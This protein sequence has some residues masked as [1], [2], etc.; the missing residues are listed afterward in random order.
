MEKIADLELGI[1]RQ[2]PEN[3]RI[4][5]RYNDPE[6]A[7]E[8][9]LVRGE[10][11]LVQFDIKSLEAIIHDNLEYGKNLTNYLFK[12]IKIKEAFTHAWTNSQSK[13]ACLRVRLFIGPSAPELHSL[14]WETLQ[15]PSSGNTIATSEN[16]FFSRYLSSL[17]WRPVRLSPKSNLRTLAVIANPKDIESYE[18]HGQ[19]LTALDVNEEHERIKTSLGT[20]FVK[21]LASGGNATL[22]NIFTNLRDGYDI[23]YII[24]H[25]ALFG[26]QPILWLEDEHGGAVRVNGRELV[27]R[28]MEIRERPRLIFFAS[29]ASAGDET[30]ECVE[31]L[32]SI[33]A[34]GPVLAEA[35]IPA[36]VAMH[37]HISTTTMEIFLPKFFAELQKN[38]TVDRALSSARGE[39][40]ERQDW[41][42]PVLFM[43][44]KSGRIW[45]TPGFADKPKSLKKLPALLA[46]IHSKK[47]TP[48]LGPGLTEP[49]LGTRR[50]IA[51]RWADTFHFPM[52]SHQREDLPQVAQY[53]A[54]DQDSNFPRYKLIEYVTREMSN[55]YA[56][57]L[58]SNS[59]ESSLVDMI[60][61]VGRNWW[62]K[63]PAETHLILAKL[64][65]PIYITTL[66]NNLLA[67][68]LKETGK[69][70]VVEFCR[71]NDSLSE[72]NTV[73]DQNPDYRP[74]VESPL[75]FHLFGHLK[76]PESIVLTEN[77]YFDYLIETSK[78][79]ILI[80]KVVSR[81]LS[82]SALLFL[83]FQVD[84]WNFRVLFRSLMR[85]EG[86]MRR[87]RYAHVA[88]QL[89]PE[90]DRIIEPEGARQFLEQFFLNS[91]LNIYWGR[92]NDFMRDLWQ[93][94]KGKT[95][96]TQ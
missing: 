27:I 23:F 60:T 4:E 71:W 95:N 49:L 38:G 87:R 76:M 16:I 72:I 81:V 56:D 22:K 89:D 84:D 92:P 35:G 59:K 69:T 77:D 11:S 33:S 54:V 91:D 39:V 51:Q 44:L 19:S 7:A 66:F 57:I 32:G 14:R 8:I 70:P 43:R 41:W 36:V 3:Y 80:P 75:V 10:P 25:G 48:I 94:Y 18:P 79:K 83:G 55:Q 26:C 58:D 12:D 9:R 45:Y 34:L 24:C 82:D 42:M 63:D 28:L 46:N 68:A 85:P 78:N 40:Q 86:Q 2:D 31:N 37:G 50:E 47:C 62:K 90:E 88:V 13:N 65:V 67:D 20:T 17:D 30:H 53:L 96:E 6:S 29:C 61:S 73:Y 5:L 15:H 93:H 21:V 1:H 52:Y 64:P 74:T